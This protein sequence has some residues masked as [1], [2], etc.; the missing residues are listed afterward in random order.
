MNKEQRHDQLVRNATVLDRIRG[1][2][3]LIAEELRHDAN[4]HQTRQV[5]ELMQLSTSATRL[6]YD[7]KAYLRA[8]KP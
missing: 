8:Y 7:L 6:S 4:W 3:D 2:C 1:D 5:T